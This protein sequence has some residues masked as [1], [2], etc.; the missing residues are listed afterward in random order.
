MAQET[1]F[2]ATI[3]CPS[4]AP[5]PVVSAAPGGSIVKLDDTCFWTNLPFAG[6]GAKSRLIGT[7]VLFG[8]AGTFAAQGYDVA[9]LANGG[10]FLAQWDESGSS[11]GSNIRYHIQS[12]TGSLAGITGSAAIACPPAK[13]GAVTVNGA[14]VNAPALVVVC[15]VTGT[16]RIPKP[17]ATAPAVPSK[18]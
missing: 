9:T 8:A 18:K 2:K 5:P 7:G 15:E 6:P 10:Q 4:F 12:G 11:T 13:I 3:T 1:P 17:A 16:Y 14:A